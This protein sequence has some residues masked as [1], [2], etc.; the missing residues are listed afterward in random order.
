MSGPE[1]KPCPRCG[2]EAK[3]VH[4]VGGHRTPECEAC[5]L[6]SRHDFDNAEQAAAWWNKRPE[7]F[8][9]DPL[10]E[11]RRKLQDAPIEVVKWLNWCLPLMCG[12]KRCKERCKP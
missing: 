4:W 1:L 7:A 2:G 6:T 10:E 8:E 9:P 5:H 11:L 3:L 12:K